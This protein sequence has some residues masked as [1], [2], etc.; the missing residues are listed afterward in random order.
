MCASKCKTTAVDTRVGSHSHGV[1]DT[2]F[3]L[4]SGV[5]VFCVHFCSQHTHTLALALELAAQNT[6]NR[7]PF[8]KH[9]KCKHTVHCM[10]SSGYALH[11]EWPK[12][13]DKKQTASRSRI[14]N[15]GRTATWARWITLVESMVRPIERTLTVRVCM[16]VS[17][18]LRLPLLVARYHCR[19]RRWT[20]IAILS[21][22]IWFTRNCSQSIETTVTE[23]IVVCVYIVYI[24]VL[25][26]HPRIVTYNI[27]IIESREQVTAHKT[28]A[29]EEKV[30]AVQH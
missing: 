13:V 26:E 14:V 7:W 28:A 8:T 22:L 9:H 18:R 23:Y 15:V 24:C 12:T 30:I 5:N 27:F 25:L 10:R 3:V 11:A 2:F 29:A 16:S 20:H 4:S 1:P 6:I 17:I 21:L 19:C